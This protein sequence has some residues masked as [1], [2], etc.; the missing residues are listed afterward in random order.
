MEKSLDDQPTYVPPNTRPADSAEDQMSTVIRETASLTFSGNLVPISDKTEAPPP[1]KIGRY[2]LRDQLG[3]GGCG[4]V[5]LAWDS[6]LERQVALKVP[7]LATPQA[8]V[9]RDLLLREA[10]AAAKL[11]H[12]NLVAVFDVG[13][14]ETLFLASAYVQGKSLSQWLRSQPF[15]EVEIAVQIVSE[16]ADAVH[17]AHENGILHRDIKPGN[18]LLDETQAS[19][20]GRLPF[21]PKLT[22]FGLAKMIATAHGNKHS[23]V[24]AGTPRYMAPEQAQPE[25]PT[26]R[27]ADV[28]A[29]GGLLYEL[30]AGKP[31]FQGD[32]VP[33]IVQ[34]VLNDDPVPPSK[35]RPTLPP[36]LD[37]VVL[38]CLEKDQN[39]RFATAAELNGMLREFLGQSESGGGLRNSSLRKSA[40]PTVVDSAP[41]SQPPL[42]A[43]RR[44]VV[45][46]PGPRSV[47]RPEHPVQ[48]EV[49]QRPNAWVVPVLATVAVGLCLG[50]TATWVLNASG[51]RAADPERPL[52]AVPA[53]EPGNIAEP[54]QV[55]S[56]DPQ[57]STQP[58]IEAFQGTPA[59][60]ET[61]GQDTAT[62]E[63]L[64]PPEEIFI[65]D[66]DLEVPVPMLRSPEA[67][68]SSFA[69]IDQYDW[70]DDEPPQPPPMNHQQEMLLGPNGPPG[71][72][73]QGRRPPMLEGEDGRPRP[74]PNGFRPGEP[75][76]T[77]PPGMGPG[78]RGRPGPGRRPPPPRGSTS[79][80][81]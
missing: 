68:F 33:D 63:R 56:V 73:G 6:V 29:L 45:N 13:V 9:V 47:I 4:T 54:D 22:D 74:D 43:S 61:P 50:V 26:G 30:L 76:F 10:R 79:L 60:P 57:S 27:P 32:S 14:E 55:A 70:Q 48:P 44:P 21:T 72:D 1:R 20:S 12:P 40:R 65:S 25:V 38:R 75:G 80:R 37:A 49:A 69:Q 3:R 42:L 36:E 78:P 24:I 5:Y 77:P 39:T 64:V 7:R 66:G 67:G 16:L 35:H 51:T 52:D 41:R 8:G 15:V 58:S 53:V 59:E 18:V 28:Y 2:E 34:R 81:P 19:P 23:S 31:A 62:R 71:D 46:T 11:Q 17:Y